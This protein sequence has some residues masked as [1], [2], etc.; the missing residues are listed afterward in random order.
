MPRVVVV[1]VVVVVVAR[2]SP[3]RRAIRRRLG[4]R[5][6]VRPIPLFATIARIQR[7]SRKQVNKNNRTQQDPTGPNI[8][9]FFQDWT[10]LDPAEPSRTSI[11]RTQRLRNIYPTFTQRNQK[12]H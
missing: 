4:L 2:P 1:V 11:S 8:S 7:F 10:Q 12:Q 5:S 6:D 3:R 9:I